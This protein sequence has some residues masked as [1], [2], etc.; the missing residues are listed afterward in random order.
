MMEVGHLPSL[1]EEE[2]GTWDGITTFSL[3]GCQPSIPQANSSIA[4]PDANPSLPALILNWLCCSLRF[5]LL[6]K[7]MGTA[8]LEK[9]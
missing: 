1:K 4:I 3:T 6:Q 8:I 9:G 2:K 7:K 5:L